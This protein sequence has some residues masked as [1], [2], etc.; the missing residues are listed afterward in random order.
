MADALTVPTTALVTAKDGGLAVMVI[1][2]DGT[3]HQKAVKV[4][5]RLP[6]TTQILEGISPGE[7]VI[8][9]GAYGIDEGTK[10]KVGA[11]D[12]DDK[13]GA[14]DQKDEGTK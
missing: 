12:A 1:G 11:A 4:G 6:E 7:M 8:T 3:A 5:I 13:A 2:A 9:G 10:V 14:G